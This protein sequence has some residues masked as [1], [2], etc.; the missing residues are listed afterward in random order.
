MNSNEVDAQY[1]IDRPDTHWCFSAYA[2]YKR[3]RGLLGWT[4]KAVAYSDDIEKCRDWI[5]TDRKLPEYH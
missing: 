3:H 4:W 2:V 5:E 1:K